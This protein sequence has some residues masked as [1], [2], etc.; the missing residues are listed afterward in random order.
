MI[1]PDGGILINATAQHHPLHPAGTGER[2]APIQNGN[3]CAN[4]YRKTYSTDEIEID[5]V[6]GPLLPKAFEFGRLYQHMHVTAEKT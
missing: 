6:H 1:C 5:K 4:E 3:N 2:L